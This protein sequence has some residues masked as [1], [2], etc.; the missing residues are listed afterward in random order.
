VIPAVLVALLSALLFAI[1]SVAQQR[2]ASQIS[3]A[4]A[5]GF[6]L[7]LALIRRPLWWA[8]F[9]GDAGG[10]LC[11][12]IA[13]GLGSLLLVQPLLV[14]SLIFALPISARW[15]GRKLGTPDW[16]W[17]GVL[18]LALAIFM[19]VGEPTEGVD[20]ASLHDW[21]YVGAAFGA[22]IALS[23]VGAMLTHGAVRASMLA[24]AT[25][26][27]F[28]LAAALTK[29]VVDQFGDGLLAP[30]SHFELYALIASGGLGVYFQQEAFQAGSLEASLP[31]MTVLEPMVAAG[32]GVAI[33]Q[34]HLRSSGL[35]IALLGV[36]VTVMIAGTVALSRSAARSGVA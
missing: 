10:Y 3:T 11:Q 27:C 16:I 30:F 36:T 33:L 14:V 18:T 19:I 15:T 35:E 32:V 7:M 12:A 29:G 21:T 5:S 8:G 6:G 23:A 22:L 26:V 24:I 17:A 13:L 1:G 2:S 20:S 28:G 9:L 31:A 4:D 25:G 34:E